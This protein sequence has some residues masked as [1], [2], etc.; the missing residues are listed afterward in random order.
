MNSVLT[1]TSTETPTSPELIDYLRNSAALTPNL[2]C[3]VDSL[4][5]SIEDVWLDHQGARLHL[6]FHAAETP[7]AV[8]VFQPGHTSYARFY[9]VAAAQFAKAGY[10]VLAIDRPGHGYSDGARGDCTISEALDVTA[11]VLDY[12]RKR[13]DLPVVLMGSSLGGILTGSAVINGLQPDLAIAHNFILPGRL[14]SMRLRAR[15][16]KRFGRR[17]YRNEEL[18]KE[19]KHISKDP[20]LLAYLSAEADPQTAWLQSPRAAASLFSHNPPRPSQPTAP[21]VVLSGTS[22]RLI[23]AWASRLFLRWSGVKP[24]EFVTVPEGGHLLF[25]DDLHLTLPIV[26][27]LIE[28]VADNS[29]I[30]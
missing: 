8:I 2:P 14:L 15:W 10:H 27:P 21:L 12:S 6:D 25:H 28:R 17:S 24:R 30:S 26:V 4:L 22:D 20:A 13:F 29:Q 23:P 1:T 19:F 11:T 5:A 7:R 18:L 3:D 9:C 16:I